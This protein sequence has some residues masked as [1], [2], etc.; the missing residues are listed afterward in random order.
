M[1]FEIFV[2]SVEDPAGLRTLAEKKFDAALRRFTSHVRRA[3]VRLE[4]ETG[5]TQHKIDK[6]CA[7]ELQL[8]GQ[9]IH[10]RE[11][12]ADFTP[13][14]DIAIDRMRAALSRQVNRAKRGIGEG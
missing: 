5:P 9:A 7:I 3:V 11:V 1:K 2:R 10:I 6:V 13:V 14:I 4:D 8:D 12:G